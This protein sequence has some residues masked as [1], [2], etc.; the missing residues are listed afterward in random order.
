MQKLK[1]TLRYPLLLCSLLLLLGLSASVAFADSRIEIASALSELYGS[2]QQVPGEFDA[3]T[4]DIGTYRAAQMNR[5]IPSPDE[6]MPRTFGESVFQLPQKSGTSSIPAINTKSL[7]YLAPPDLTISADPGQQV[8]NQVSFSVTLSPNPSQPS[9]AGNQAVKVRVLDKS[10]GYLQAVAEVLLLVPASGGS[11]SA[12]VGIPAPQ[13]AAGLNITRD[14]V[15]IVDPDNE[16]IESNE[17]NNSVA[18][19]GSCSA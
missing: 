13:T 8:C 15:V 18:I 7:S 5:D 2:T 9:P 16:I 3:G 4:Y 14:I 19:T 17:S 6:R 10:S 11:T 1:F 12:D